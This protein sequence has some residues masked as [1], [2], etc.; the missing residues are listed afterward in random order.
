MPLRY[1]IVRRFLRIWFAAVFRKIRL[2]GA[3]DEAA[4]GATML[5]VSHPPRVLDVLLL[6][7]IFD[8]QLHCL[9]DTQ[10]AS[11]LAGQFL[12]WSLGVIA[13]TSG[14]GASNGAWM[15]MCREWLESKG[16][17]VVFSNSVTQDGS[18][19]ER[20][21][22][23]AKI[24]L[25]VESMSPASVESAIL[26]VHLLT[27]FARFTEVLIHFGEPVFP[28]DFLSLPDRELDE[29]TMEL[30][31]ALSRSCH[32][33]PF[34]LRQHDLTQLLTD[35]AEILRIDLADEWAS[36]PDWK[37]TIE[38]F[39]LSRFLRAWAE[40]ENHADPE[41]LVT[42]RRALNA[43][44]EASRRWSLGTLQ[45]E[46]AA[47]TKSTLRGALAWVES[48][49]GLPVAGYGFL[50][51]VPAG[52][53]VSI[54][55]L[56]KRGKRVRP[57][58]W[59]AAGFFLLASYAGA[60]ALVYHWFGRS[61]AGYYAVTL[62]TSGAYLWRWTWLWRHRTRLLL[63]GLFAPLAARRLLRMRKEVIARV[64]TARSTYAD[65]LAVA[66]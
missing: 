56:H 3:E 25:E 63:L 60:I 46:N 20:L 10:T 30:A 62:P 15:E 31:R 16:I 8:R 38:G 41:K 2:L 26:P 39:T 47:W 52:L 49:L 14:M 1:R 48:A 13:P 66:H 64:E 42:L 53:L 19:S 65:V 29:Q 18:P 54:M 17:V 55:G 34:A 33:N 57:R 7:A 45:I 22:S 4:S 32:A 5:L 23:V 35:L 28:Q 44:R 43:C 37:Q 61:T 59:A 36:K 27:P 58:Q 9:I 51:H 50:N 24:A 11:G 6:V 40:Q 21:I 12:T